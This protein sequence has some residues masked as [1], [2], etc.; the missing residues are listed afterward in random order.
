MVRTNHWPPAAR[1]CLGGS[2]S[3]GASAHRLDNPLQR[4][5]RDV[6]TM[7]AHIV[8]DRDTHLPPLGRA[9]LGRPPRA[10]WR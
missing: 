9:L 3:A 4:V 10:I 2:K 5:R 7:A 8:F 1:T 6:N